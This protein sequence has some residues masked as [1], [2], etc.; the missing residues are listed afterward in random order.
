MKPMKYIFVLCMVCAI[1]IS[2][3]AKVEN[4][5]TFSDQKTAQSQPTRSQIVIVRPKE[6]AGQ[7]I[8][9]Y[10]DG[11]YVS[12][13]LPGAYTEEF[14]CPGKHRVNL[15]YT[16]VFSRYKEKRSGGNLIHF[17]SNNKQVYMLTKEADR[18]QFKH[19]PQNNVPKLLKNYTKKQSH[20]IS[21]LNKRQC[22]QPA[23]AK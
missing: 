8:N 13:L 6:L 18:L 5:D 12:S 16:N 7:A 17:K 4:W 3:S 15:A 11:E 19:Y 23:A 1:S 2:L 21:R 10:I 14:V 22:T 20:T 9:I